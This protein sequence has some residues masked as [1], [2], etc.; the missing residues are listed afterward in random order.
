M[1][2]LSFPQAS[3]ARNEYSDECEAAI[4]KQIKWVNLVYFCFDSFDFQIV[5]S[6][7]E[8]PCMWLANWELGFDF[9]W[10]WMRTMRWVVVALFW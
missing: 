8:D 1:L 9:G 5:M 4:N 3:I 2:A 7:V 6:R 10:W